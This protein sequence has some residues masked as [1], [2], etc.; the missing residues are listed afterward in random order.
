MNKHVFQCSKAKHRQG[1]ESWPADGFNRSG[2]RSQNSFIVIGHHAPP[3]HKLHPIPGLRA[4]QRM[5]TLKNRRA[6]TSGRLQGRSRGFLWHGADHGHGVDLRLLTAQG[7]EPV[8][9]AVHRAQPEAVFWL[10]V[11]FHAQA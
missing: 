8:T 6:K 5:G 3:R 4:A 11:Q 1:H 10:E 2:V 7:F 9:Q